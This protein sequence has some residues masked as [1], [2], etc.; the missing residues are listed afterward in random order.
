MMGMIDALCDLDA[1]VVLFPVRHHSPA[2]ARRVGSLIRAMRPAA[3]LVEGPS[4]FND[5]LGELFL[6][7][8]LPIAIYSFVRLDADRRHSAYYPFC[9]Y[10]PEWQA[11][12]AAKEVGAA[13]RFIDLPWADMARVDDVSNRYADHGLRRSEYVKQLCRETGVETFDDFWDR[14]FELDADL[15]LPEFLRRCHHFC[16]HS[17]LLEEVR[18]S[19]RLREAFMVKEVRRAMDEFPGRILVVTGGYHSSAI[20]E[21]LD[22]A[23]DTMDEQP[24][25]LPEGTERGI[26]L[27]PYSYER[28]DNL[29]GYDSGMPN[30]GFYHQVWQDLGTNRDSHRTLLAKVATTLRK[31]GQPVSAADLIAGESTARGLARFR[32]HETV[33]RQDLV[34]GVIGA[35]IKEER[36]IGL[37]HPLLDAVHEVLRGGER[38]ALAEG[39]VLP[40]LVIDLRALLERH[41]LQP[42][43]KSRDLE[44]N[45]EE[46]PA[47]E[48]SR[49]LHR[50]RILPVAGF[51]RTGGTDL[52]ART[53]LSK[54][55][56]RWKIVWTP[57]YDATAIEAAR[58][59]STLAEAAAAKLAE[60][61]AAG[62]LKAEDAATL[63]LDASLAGLTRLA[64][65][66]LQRLADLI[67]GDSDFFSVTKSLG[68]L[69]HLFI[70]DHVLE[71]AGRA[72]LAS[73]VRETF[74]RGLWLLESLG[75][76]AG[77]DKELLAGL[78]TLLDAF[79][80]CGAKLNLDR[81]E[82]VSVFHRVGEEK[83]QT[84]L[85]RGAA[86]GT[87]WTIGE[88]DAATVFA[89]LLLFS[90]PEHLGD[91][92]TGLF[93][94]ARETVQ[95]HR[96]LVLSID[97]LLAA[98]ADEEFLT[99]LP[100]LR[101][102]FTYFTP[103]EKHHLGLTLLEALG[104]K[105]AKSLTRLEATPEVMARA[106]AFES[107][108]FETLRKHGLRGAEPH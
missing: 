4:D 36:A 49:V 17:R 54:I 25:A 77:R 13:I 26:A 39:T 21:R 7:H 34:D 82:F 47:R 98:Y 103:R 102:A 22:G 74:S 108:L 58:Y 27:T 1:R 105:E 99:A 61:A 65:E 35:L 69:L 56:E 86:A 24:E 67:R 9:V 101:L 88:S 84:P 16:L 64:G 15:P 92:L 85:V 44:L 95:R 3:V 2:C 55:W 93:C 51:Q 68:H 97:R 33:W 46:T 32:G 91:F 107:R 50:L 106:M 89:Q 66:F 31:R 52:I 10:S 72:D 11:L 23:N 96:E 76:V 28:L 43:M 19:D 42:E 60:Q 83:R 20:R 70:H 40:P 80:R 94:M 14:C 87:L 59:G 63:L 53:D 41:E 5:R 6:P 8:R 45:L 48:R 73:L 29:R 104:I 62:D 71:T 79:E 75:Q 57:D 37:G 78:K 30:P 38:G 81:V 18:P 100:S 90:D 12:L